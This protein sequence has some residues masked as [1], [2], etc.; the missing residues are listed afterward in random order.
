MSQGTV[1][2]GR[3]KSLDGIRAV[4]VLAVIASHVQFPGARG[5][6]FGVLVFFVLS[7]FLITTLLLQERDQTGRISLGLFYARRALRLFPALVLVIVATIVVSAVVLPG[8]Q[9]DAS[10]RAVPP[11]L[12]YYANWEW[13]AHGTDIDV[14]GYFGH[15]WSLSVEEQFYLVWPVVLILML[16]R[17]SE[18]TVAAV[19]LVVCAGS[20]VIRLATIH[21]LE[22]SHLLFGTH[23]IA[24]QLAWGA[25]LAVLLRAAPAQW[26]RRSAVALWPAIIVAVGLMLTVRADADSGWGVFS[27]TL[28]PTLEA[29]AT[30]VVVGHVVTSGS[31]VSRVLAWRPAVYVGEISYGMYLWHILILA[32]VVRRVGSGFA[33]DLLVV[34]LTV[35]VASCSYRWW[36]QPFRRLKTRFEPRVPVTA[37]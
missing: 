8:V 4:A 12:F 13:F 23:A 33:A 16:R 25:L 5:G 6:G 11:A 36:E 15:F 18:R 14:L 28:A 20:L 19:L 21:D 26:A 32:V 27:N 29:V 10:V 30:A 1:L 7:G 22:T 2:A 9:G 37:P 24:D 35:V 31:V 17:V 3:N 34:A